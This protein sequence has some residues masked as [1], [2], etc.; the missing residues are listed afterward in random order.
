[1]STKQDYRRREAARRRA[2]QADFVASPLPSK[3]AA[4]DRVAASVLIV[5]MVLVSIAGGLAIV[6]A[7]AVQ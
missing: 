1:M 2:A 4:R 6:A 5:V 3:R 7:E